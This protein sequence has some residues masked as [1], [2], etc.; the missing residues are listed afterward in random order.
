M[1]FVV[2]VVLMILAGVGAFVLGRLTV[3]SN[4]VNNIVVRKLLFLVVA[5]CGMFI[6]IAP[7]LYI[8]FTMLSDAQ[9]TQAGAP[10]G[11]L[12]E[13]LYPVSALVYYAVLYLSFRMG[14]GRVHGMG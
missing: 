7:V 13:L 1:T 10:S 14:T 6:A 12:Q 11:F 5:L 2:G 8:G 3:F 9:S 4:R